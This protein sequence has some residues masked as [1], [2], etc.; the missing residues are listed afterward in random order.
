MPYNQ[1]AW[2]RQFILVRL[3]SFTIF[4]LDGACSLYSYSVGVFV[5]VWLIG[6]TQFIL[7][8]GWS[9]CFIYCLF[10]MVQPVYTRECFWSTVLFTVCLIW[11]SQFIL[12]CAWSN[13][14]Y[15]LFDMVQSVYTRECLEWSFFSLFHIYEADSLDSS[16]LG[17]ILFIIF[18][19][20]KLAVYTLAAL[21]YWFHMI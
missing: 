17:V 12:V 11:C 15:W 1:Y 10:D 8:S 19:Y 21:E 4:S 7:M 16:S 18:I 9:I 20:M 6:F 5:F 13:F 3:W 2:C 14:L